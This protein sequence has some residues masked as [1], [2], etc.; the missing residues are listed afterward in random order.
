MAPCPLPLILM[1]LLLLGGPAAH[2]AP[3]RAARHSDGTFTS[4]LSRLRDSA[5]L[6]RL[7]QGLVGKRSDQDTENS[8]TGS[9]PVDSPLC[10]LWLD[11]STLQAW[12]LLGHSLGHAPFPWLPPD[13]RPE[14]EISE[15]AGA[16]QRPDEEEEESGG[17]LGVG[18]GAGEG[19]GAGAG[20]GADCT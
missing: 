10:L 3:P 15:L 2:P 14:A 7:L 18:A 6:Q 13:P 11:T 9:K 20:A 4:E 1:L 5:R 19:A 16:T 12:M 8:T 17:W